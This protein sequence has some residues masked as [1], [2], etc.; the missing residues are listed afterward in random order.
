MRIPAKRGQDKF[1]C[2]FSHHFVQIFL[3]ELIVD[4]ALLA[5]CAISSFGGGLRFDD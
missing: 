1:S 2:I 3:S 5:Y 4:K